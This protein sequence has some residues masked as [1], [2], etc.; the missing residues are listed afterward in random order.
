[1]LSGISEFARF[2]RIFSSVE[3]NLFRRIFDVFDFGGLLYLSFI[4]C[5][6]QVKRVHSPFLTPWAKGGLS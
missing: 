4:F 1:M 6:F 2:E 3:F 5:A